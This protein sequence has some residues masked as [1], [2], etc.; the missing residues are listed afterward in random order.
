[1]KFRQAYAT[2]TAQIISKMENTT[3]PVT[4]SSY[5]VILGNRI[6]R[7]EMHRLKQVE[8][9]SEADKRN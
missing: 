6:D 8:K 9:E 4:K 3:N 1:M 2:S 5:R 7:L